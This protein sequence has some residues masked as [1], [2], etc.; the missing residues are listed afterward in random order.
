M[1]RGAN[2]QTVHLYK[3]LTFYCVGNILTTNG[4]RLYNK[5]PLTTDWKEYYII[6]IISHEPKVLM[7]MY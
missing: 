7:Q 1:C 6:I 2:V 3:M 5:Y 4:N